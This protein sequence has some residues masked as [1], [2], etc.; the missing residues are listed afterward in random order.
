[1]EK[2]GHSD[3]DLADYTG[4]TV[5]FA[6]VLVTFLLKAMKSIDIESTF[7]FGAVLRSI[8]TPFVEEKYFATFWLLFNCFFFLPLFIHSSP[9]QLTRPTL[10]CEFFL[11]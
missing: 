2:H 8:L 1:M 9:G 4:V 5:P 6:N 7:C 10:M 3:S 11:V